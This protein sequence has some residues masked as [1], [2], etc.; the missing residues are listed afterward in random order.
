MSVAYTGLILFPL[1]L[2]SLVAFTT[3]LAN[4]ARTIFHSPSQLTMTSSSLL[5]CRVA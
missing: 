2:P 5:G 1:P 4:A 3:S